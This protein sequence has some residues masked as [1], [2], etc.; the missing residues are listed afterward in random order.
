[1]DIAIVTGASSGLGREFVCQLSRTEKLDEI[2]VIARRKEK[3]EELKT[4][5]PSPGI[6]M[7]PMDLTEF[8]STVL[9]ASVLEKVKPE[10]K[11]LINNA[12][13]GKLGECEDISPEDTRNM[14][15]LNC[16]VP[17]VVTRLVLPFMKEGSRIINIASTA[18]FQPLPGM[19]VYGASKTFVLNYSRA[20][21]E[22]LRPKGIS[23][24]AVCPYWIRDTEFIGIAKEGAK[25]R[26]MNLLFSSR[27][28]DIAARALRASRH[29]ASVSTPGWVCT[30]D[31][32][33]TSLLPAGVI[34]KLWNFWKK[35]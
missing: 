23:V 14:I 17:A 28:A 8:S 32:I 1:M 4:S 5:I 7:F 19:A 18:A 13:M 15:E 22:E 3:L 33:T 16:C 2:W 34:M 9:L 31:R 35:L 12:G 11:I 25:D 29:G 24:T 21:G 27:A 6:H 20:L 30:A 26:K 10:V